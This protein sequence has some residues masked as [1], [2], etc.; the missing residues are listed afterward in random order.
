MTLSA[1]FWCWVSIDDAKCGA[2][3]LVLSEK[4]DLSQAGGLGALNPGRMLYV[5]LVVEMTQAG[6]LLSGFLWCSWGQKLVRMTNTR[7]SLS[8]NLS[9]LIRKMGQ[10]GSEVQS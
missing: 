6:S 4:K 1:W 5:L 9:L 8:L 2:L 3:G 10:M 7:L